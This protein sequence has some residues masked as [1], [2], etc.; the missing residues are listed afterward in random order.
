MFSS[1]SCFFS[2]LLVLSFSP[3]FSFPPCGGKGVET[4][5]GRRTGEG[6]MYGASMAE[7][8]MRELII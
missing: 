3:H 4:D 7:E 2:N 1:F 8:I 5:R 6:E